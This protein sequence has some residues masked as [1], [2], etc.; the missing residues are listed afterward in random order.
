M[1]KLI[2]KVF[3]GDQTSRPPI[4]FMRQAGRVLPSYMKLRNEH[5]FKKLMDTPQM[6]SKVTLLPVY[7]LGVDA[8][9]LFSD[10]L[11]VPEAL[12]MDLRFDPKPKFEVALKDIT[13]YHKFLKFQPERLQHIYDTID[14][15]TKEIPKNIG[16][17]GFC[18]APFTVLCYMFEG[19]GTDK[20]FSNLIRAIYEEKKKIKI[21]IE[22]ITEMSIIYALNQVKH[23]IDV[24]Q[25]FDTHAGLLPFKIYEEIFLPS[26]R[27]ILKSVREAGVKTIFFPKGIGVGLQNMSYDITDGLSVDWQTPISN[28]RKWV[29]DELV[30]QG[31]IDP[32]ILLTTPKII[33]NELLKYY[34]FGKTEKKWIFNLGHGV[35]PNT[36]FENAKYL[37][38]KIRN[39]NWK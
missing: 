23:G 6:A 8:A 28:L 34:E 3:N 7:E 5:G 16:L 20:T 12:G 21:V 15:I 2:N 36:P 30:L 37:V 29:G 38:D 39:I 18:G 31:N 11:V 14:I 27:K 35:L 17:I 33:D 22:K 26:V 19:L 24:F 32:R 10:I 25:L 13:D 1:D 9:I 4:W